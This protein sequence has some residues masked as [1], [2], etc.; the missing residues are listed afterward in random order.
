MIETQETQI[1]PMPKHETD[2]VKVPRNDAL[3][4]D[5]YTE[6]REIVIRPRSGWIAI[7]WDEMIAHR[8]LLAF[9]IWRDIVI[10]YKQTILGSAWA[11]LQPLLM[12]LIFTFVFGRF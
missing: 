2:Q 5:C 7:N 8:E 9:L 6:Y 3:P 10:R 1:A 4:A 11:I 12:M